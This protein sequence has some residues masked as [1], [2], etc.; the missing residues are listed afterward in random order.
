MEEFPFIPPRRKSGATRRRERRE[1]LLDP[2]VGLPVRYA[3]D[4]PYPAALPVLALFAEVEGFRVVMGLD[5][6]GR[7]V[8][9]SIHT[10]NTMTGAE[11]TKRADD[12]RL[13]GR[14]GYGAPVH[15]RTP[16]KARS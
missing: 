5:E 11:Q 14:W 13:I 9:L 15:R 1:A 3:H 6:A 12:P 2:T 4:Y 10:G 16:P 8:G 7:V